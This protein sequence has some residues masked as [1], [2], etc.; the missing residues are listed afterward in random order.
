MTSVQDWRNICPVHDRPREDSLWM[1]TSGV[2]VLAMNAAFGLLEAGCVKGM[3]RLNILMKNL[4]DLALGGLAWWIF[5]YRIAF[6]KPSGNWPVSVQDEAFWFLQWTFASTAATIDSGAVA[7]RINY[8]SYCLLSFIITGIVYPTMVR[9]AWADDGWLRKEGFHDYAGGGIV[10][11]LG[12]T[13]AL[14]LCSILGPRIGRFTDYKPCSQIPDRIHKLCCQRNLHPDY[15]L[16]PPGL[17]QLVPVCDPVSMVWGV[18]F[19]WIGWYGFNPGAVPNIE[20]GGTYVVGHIMM[21]ITMG[22]LGGGNT[23]LFFMALFR[24]GR[25]TAEG[26]A[27]GVLAGLVSILPVALTLAMVSHS[28]LDLLDHSSPSVSKRC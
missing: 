25:I 8:F 10:H 17:P 26:L 28:C 11:L 18:F 1:L 5:G 3:N 27:L 2:L 15:Y 23:G 19:L 13:C 6:G 4:S 9:L 22:A 21:N 16:L 7:E 12:G 24:R 20:G 14:V